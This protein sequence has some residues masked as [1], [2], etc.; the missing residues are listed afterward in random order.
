MYTLNCRGRLLLL[1][2]PVVMGILNITPDSFYADSR[3]HSVDEAVA[4]AENM[5]AAGATILDIGGQS[6]RPGAVRLPAADETE[7]ITPVIAAIQAHF[8]EA[9]LSIDTYHASVAKAA[10]EAGAVIVNDISGGLFDESMIT[11][12]AELNTPFVCMHVKGT[13]ATMHQKGAYKHLLS[14][15][16]DDLLQKVTTCRKAGIQDIILDPGFGFSKQSTENL[17]LVGC[18]DAFTHFDMPVLLGV[19]RKS[20]IYKLLDTSPEQALNGTTVLHTI[21]LLKGAMILRVHDVREAVEAIR[22]VEAVKKSG[23]L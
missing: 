2:Q 21:G 8:P 22:L 16:L 10:V 5:L 15:I 23:G 17:A 19:S 14:D 12:V 13:S 7:R 9:I 3:Q 18:L 6:T 11:T 20:T 1:D 4:A